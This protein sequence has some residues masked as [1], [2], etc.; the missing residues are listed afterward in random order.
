MVFLASY[1][2]TANETMQRTRPL[3]LE[4]TWKPRAILPAADILKGGFWPASPK[5]NS[6]SEGHGFSEDRLS[7]VPA[8][9]VHPR[10]LVT[11]SDVEIIRAKVALGEQAPQ[12]FRTLWERAEQG[13]GA[14]YALVSKNHKLGQSLALKFMEKV[15]S[16]NKK[17]PNLEAQADRENLW[18]V[19]RS[20][21]ASGDPNPPTEIWSLLD[22]DYLYDWLSPAER[23]ET[24]AVIA[25]LTAGRVSNFMIVPDHMMINNHEGFGMEFIRLILLIEGEQGFDSQVFKICTE[26]IHAMLDWYL[27]DQGMCYE[28]IKGWLNISA[29]VAAGHRDRNILKHSHLQAKMRFFAAALHWE[30][31]KWVIRD[32]MRASAFH[33]IWLMHYLY[34]EE[35]LYELLYSAS[36]SSHD[37]LMDAKVRWPNP[38]GTCEEL[39]LLHANGIGTKDSKQARDWQDQSRID[40]LQL[41][42]TWKDDERGYLFTRNSWRKDDLHLGFVCKQDFFYGGH[43]GS[44][45]NRITLWHGGVNWIR[46]LNMLAVKAT[47][48]QNMLTVDGQGLAWPPCPGVWLGVQESPEGVTAA[49]DG[50]IAYSFAK[51]M[52]VHPLDFP[53]AQLPYYAPFAEGNYDLRRDQQI[54][55]HPGTVQWNDGYAH[56]D[57]GPWSGETRLVESYRPNN[58]MEQC[59]RTVH[60]ARGQHPYVLV[61]DDAR[62]DGLK[63]LYDWNISLPEDVELLDAKTP[64]VSFQR[65]EPM[66]GRE[67]DLILTRPLTPRDPVSGKPIVKKGEPLFLVRV[68]WRNSPYGF[69]VPR[70]ERFNG[71]PEKPFMRFSHLTVPAISESPEF[72]ILL[73]P[74]FQGDPLPI[75]SW[76]LNR[77]KLTVQLG[78]Q[79]D[80]YNLAQTDGGRT[81]FSMTRNMG[82]TKN[83][84]A[85][86]A[87][88]PL[89]TPTSLD[90]GVGPAR[91]ILKIHD[92]LLDLNDARTTRNENRAPEFKFS[93]EI[94]VALVRPQA[95][96]QIRITLDGS[97]PTEFSDLYEA[98]IILNHSATLK[99]KCFDSNWPGQRKNSLTTMA[100][101]LKVAPS[102]SLMEP[103]QDTQNGVLARVYEKKTVLWNDR[104]FFDAKRIM[105]PDLDREIPTQI[106]SM[107]LLQLPS[108]IPT[109]PIIEQVKGFYRFNGWIL[110]KESGVCTFKVFSCGPVTLDIGGQTAIESIGVFHQ[111]LDHRSGE[112]VL[113]AGWHRFELVV[114]DPLFWNMATT[115][116]MPFAVSLCY[117]YGREQAISPEDLR[118]KKPE[119]ELFKPAEVKWLE[120]A[121]PPLWLEPGAIGLTYDREGKNLDPQYLDLD[122]LF[123]LYTEQVDEFKTNPRPDLVKTYEAWLYAPMTG[124]Y[125]FYLPTRREASAGLGE[126]RAAFQNQL[127]IGGEIVVQRGIAGRNPLS[128]LGLKKGWHSFSLRLGASPAEGT[129]TFPDGQ[130]LPLNAQLV[131]RASQVEIRPKGAKQNQSAWEIYGPTEVTFALPT[132]RNGEIRYRQ[133]GSLPTAS[134]PLCPA[135][136][137]INQSTVLIA[138]AFVQGQAVSAPVVAKFTKVNVPEFQ[139]ISKVDFN[140]WNGLCGDT[141]LDHGSRLFIS[142]GAILDEGR[143]G[144]KAIAIHREADNSP[145]QLD[146]NLSRGLGGIGFKL[147]DLKMKDNALTVGLW[148]KSATANG[149]IFGKNGYN[150]F[151]KS[152]KTV[153]CSLENGVIRVDPSRI[154]GGKISKGEWHHLVVSID[155]NEAVIYLNGV[156]QAQG[157]GCSTLATDGFDFFTQH[158][159]TVDRMSVYN[160]VLSAGDIEQWY[161]FEN[162][163]EIK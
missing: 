70:L 161:K 7:E 139:R 96:A 45:S 75:T 102:I 4:S 35:K 57:Y 143:Q 141:Q 66:D 94:T 42:L 149:K 126:L 148:F 146:G 50:K 20:I 67:N 58:P 36:L 107:P 43:E 9:G 108:T 111:Q 88:E 3:Y 119:G 14:F 71:S 122:G 93:Q 1:F 147:A 112:A 114:C 144:R 63:H 32:E 65:V 129:I 155:E 117:E 104:G 83:N 82:Q 156:V 79:C 22:Y 28:S 72:R 84:K 26:R 33:V 61:F 137:S 15:R 76:N 86:A 37:F 124:H 134:S 113:T 153:S 51:V 78:E 131:S 25:Q 59:Y 53:S 85:L 133:D 150:A 38:V 135:S 92:Q 98:P 103:P 152:Y 118:F 136:M 19:E 68:L 99:A 159:A 69:P 12:E 23:E 158:S 8:P 64:E 55:F 40:Q 10:V 127:R 29:F 120:A 41:P 162:K 142:P 163:G 100:R 47:F 145:S 89:Q 121:C 49:G 77:T 81:V 110:I 31:G 6:N 73:Y 24:R 132:Q 11:P 62:K 27:N 34:P 154:K 130:S 13:Q 46:D 91:P 116:T 123:P 2:C 90:C 138:T 101:F 87:S 54:A 21:V 52:Q 18:C 140:A 5:V 109:H 157:R 128:R 97:E 56:T 105:M 39:L 80:V 115:E 16:L 44:E 48:L 95:P 125:Q 60:L 160:R 30:N 106:S 17:L 74:H 151:G